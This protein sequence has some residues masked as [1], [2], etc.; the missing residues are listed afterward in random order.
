[1]V[2]LWDFIIKLL[3]SKDPII[4]VEYDIILIVVDKYTKWGYFII[5]IEEITAKDLVRIY[6]KEVFVR[7]GLLAKIISDWDLKFILEF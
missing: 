7:H 1:M 3:K 5:C 6:T 4:G 2:I